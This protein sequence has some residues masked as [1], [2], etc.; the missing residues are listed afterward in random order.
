MR[1]LSIV[2]VA[3]AASWLLAAVAAEAQVI[4]D[5]SG[6]LCVGD[7]N[8][9]STYTA[10][11]TT[12]YNFK[13]RLTVYHNDVLKHDS[14]TFITQSGPFYD[15]SKVVDHTGWGLAVNDRLNYHG[16]A[17]ITAGPYRGQ[18]DEKDWLVTVTS[19]TCRAVFARREDVA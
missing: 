7:G 16:R 17:T 3:G 10:R 9:S 12:N 5:P 11:V 6:P 14:T 19:G 15:F 13:V 2:L 18:F 4:I 1:R 8:T